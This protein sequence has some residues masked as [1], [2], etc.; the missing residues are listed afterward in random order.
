MCLAKVYLKGGEKDELLM[1][2]VAL[3][4]SKQGK[5]SL[6]TLFGEETEIEAAIKEIDFANSNVL[7]EK[8]S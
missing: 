2:E 1:E 8:R 4:K 3:V 6:R 7:L 5:L